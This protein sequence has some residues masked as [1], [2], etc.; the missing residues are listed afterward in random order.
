MH[1]C[2]EVGE[3]S[4]AGVQGGVCMHVG[5]VEGMGR[6]RGAHDGVCMRV[7]GE[8]RGTW[9]VCKYACGGV[10]GRVYSKGTGC[11]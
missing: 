4:T 11:V 2:G 6:G 1:A 3:E 5:E 7:A 10:G 9:W 8:G